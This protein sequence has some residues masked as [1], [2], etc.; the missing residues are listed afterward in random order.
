[1]SI[2]A[3]AGIIALTHFQV[4][5]HVEGIIKVR[6]DETTRANGL[7][8]DLK[9]TK[10]TLAQTENQ[11]K[12]TKAKLDDTEQQLASTSKKLGDE[13]ARA[14]KLNSDLDKTKTELTDS[15]QKLEAWRLIELTPAQVKGVI[16]D[17]KKLQVAND[18][19]EEEKQVLQV[20]IK[21]L[22][23]ELESY[24][25]NEVLE[26]D[27]P[28]GLKG[29]VLVVDPKWDFVVLDVGEKQNVV[30]NGVMMVS[31]EGKLIAKVRI[32]SVQPERS[33]ANIMSQ[34]RLGEV[35]EGDLV[36]SKK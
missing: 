36:L 14:N 25:T 16:D 3:G 18:V 21:K 30:Q 22:D 10:S 8:K 5:P 28:A 32:V 29:T 27:L 6:N 13:T 1:V 34:W 4:K 26:A 23:K 35:M 15:R 11:L 2:L 9:K 7:D 17:R 20:H 31:R 24:R 19:L 12:S 33:I